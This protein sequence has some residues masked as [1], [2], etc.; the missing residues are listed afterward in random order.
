ME[1]SAI[2]ASRLTWVGDQV[3]HTEVSLGPCRTPSTT[4]KVPIALC[5]SRAGRFEGSHIE[6]MVCNPSDRIGQDRDSAGRGFVRG[7]AGSK[8]SPASD[9]RRERRV[10]RRSDAP[11]DPYRGAR[12]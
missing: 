12:V 8:W 1:V 10:A 3:K 9:A 11:N 6:P 4:P 2:A 7:S 5:L